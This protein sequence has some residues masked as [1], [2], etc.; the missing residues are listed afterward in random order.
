MDE[1][2]EISDRETSNAS[3]FEQQALNHSWLM[4]ESAT[5]HNLL[6][7]IKAYMAK[8]RLKRGIEMVKLAN[9]IEALRMQ[10]DD[11]E[12]PDFPADSKDAAKDAATANSSDPPREKKSLSRIARG[13]IFREVVLAK[14]REMKEQEQTLKVKEEAEKEARRRSFN[15]A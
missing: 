4:G 6:P 8:A 15:G 3:N 12:N 7:E 5:D 9:R 10:E 2:G 14:V 11:P 13:A 1:S